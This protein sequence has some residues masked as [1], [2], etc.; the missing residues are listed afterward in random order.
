MGWQ[1]GTEQTSLRL[2]GNMCV[3]AGR[4]AVGGFISTLAG[5]CTVTYGRHGAAGGATNGG[6]EKKNGT[7]TARPL[8]FIS[9]GSAGG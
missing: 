3:K 8:L 2:F 6:L 1:V 4:W 5:A 7:D 9:L